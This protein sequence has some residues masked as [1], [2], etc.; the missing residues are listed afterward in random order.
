M[1]AVAVWVSWLAAGCA[2]ASDAGG[3]GTTRAA[4][5]GPDA[6]GTPEMLVV[7]L[8]VRADGGVALLEA[9]RAEDRRNPVRGNPPP[10]VYRL[11]VLDAA[12][13]VLDSTSFDVNLVRTLEDPT[14]DAADPHVRVEVSAAPALVRIGAPPEATTLRVVRRERHGGEAIAAEARIDDLERAH[15]A[16]P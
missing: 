4:V 9:F 6:A 11:D 14:P 13:R 10:T 2:P 7:Q 16:R 5:A 8:E 1:R 3:S 12:G 15:D